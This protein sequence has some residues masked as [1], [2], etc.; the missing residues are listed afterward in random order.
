MLIS[1]QFPTEEYAKLSVALPNTKSDKFEAYVHISP[2]GDKDI[3]VVG[4]RKPLLNSNSKSD[5]KRLQK[6]QEQ[7]KEYQD[8]YKM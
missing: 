8:K 5:V 1:N 2:I 7:F 6:Y 4:K 3:M